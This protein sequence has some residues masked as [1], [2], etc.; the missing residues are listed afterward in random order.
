MRIFV[1]KFAD[2]LANIEDP[3]RLNLGHHAQE[4]ARR[5]HDLTCNNPLRLVRLAL[6]IGLILLPTA[7]LSV[8]IKQT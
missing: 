7:G 5:L 1:T 6:G 2:V 4:Q 3:L 8:A